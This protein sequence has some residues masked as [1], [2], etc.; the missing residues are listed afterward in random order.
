MERSKYTFK[1]HDSNGAWDTAT[2]EIGKDPGENSFPT[3]DPGENSASTL[4]KTR[5]SGGNSSKTLYHD[6][7]T[8]HL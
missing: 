6:Y 2:P 1:W 3:E 5:D 4:V 7:G 8:D